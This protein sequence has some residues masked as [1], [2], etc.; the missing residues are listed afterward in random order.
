MAIKTSPGIVTSSTPNINF[1]NDS[2]IDAWLKQH[3]DEV[4]NYVILDDMAV[5]N[6]TQSQQSHF[7]H[8]N[9]SV[10]LNRGIAEKVIKFLSE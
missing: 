4:D 8:V 5:D 6:F 10:G 7:F 9:R 2:E 1:M 3:E